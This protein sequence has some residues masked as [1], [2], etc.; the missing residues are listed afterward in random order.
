VE[1][2]GIADETG[3][4]IV[5]KSVIPSHID[6]S[7]NGFLNTLGKLEKLDDAAVGGEQSVLSYQHE[8]SLRFSLGLCSFLVH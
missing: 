8:V 3:C 4:V 2:F 1:S 5:P 7:M 6:A